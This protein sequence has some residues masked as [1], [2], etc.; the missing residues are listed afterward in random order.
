MVFRG[1]NSNGKYE[2]K[3]TKKTKKSP[4]SGGHSAGA[5]RVAV[6][7]RGEP[8]SLTTLREA[9]R[10]LTFDELARAPRARRRAGARSG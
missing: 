1:V 10:P 8:A 2:M 4:K 3:S 6:A 9:G 5:Q 7:A